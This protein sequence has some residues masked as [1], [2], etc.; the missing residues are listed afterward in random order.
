MVTAETGYFINENDEPVQ[1]AR[2]YDTFE[3]RGRSGDFLEVTLP[4]GKSAR[5]HRGQVHS[6]SEHWG[7]DTDRFEMTGSIL[8]LLQQ[9]EDAETFDQAESFLN[10]ATQRSRDAFGRQSLLVAW[11]QAIHAVELAE[12]GDM[13]SARSL[14]RKA[15]KRLEDPEHKDQLLTAEIFN[16]DGLIDT[17]SGRYSAA[18]KKFLTA[19][20]I[21]ERSLG[22]NHYDIA[23]YLQ[24]PAFAADPDKELAD[25]I[26]D[27]RAA[28]TILQKV[29][30][31]TAIE[32]PRGL[33]AL[34]DLYLDGDQP[35]QAIG[36]LM[37]AMG[38]LRAYHPDGKVDM[39]ICQYHLGEAWQQR[40]QYLEA[41]RW[42]NGIDVRL[43]NNAAA[44][45]RAEMLSL[46]KQI[47]H[48]LGHI[49]FE[50]RNFN[51]ALD[52]YMNAAELIDDDDMETLDGWSYVYA[53]D[54]LAEMRQGQ[55][56]QRLYKGAW[57]MF[58]KTDGPQSELAL[59]AKQL[60]TEAGGVVAANRTTGNSDSSMN[61]SNL[62]ETIGDAPQGLSE[63]TDA[64]ILGDRNSELAAYSM[65]IRRG[66][67]MLETKSDAPIMS[68]SDVLA[69]VPAATKLWSLE[70]KDG[71]HKVVIPG[72]ARRAWISGRFVES[73]YEAKARSLS[74][75]VNQ[76]AG[77]SAAAGRLNSQLLELIPR[78]AETAK[79][80]GLEAAVA[81]QERVVSLMEEA[82]GADSYMT[83]SSRSHLAI[84]YL[85]SRQFVK[86]RQLIEAALPTMRQ[87]HGD[88]HPLIAR[89]LTR[90]AGLLGMIGD[91]PGRQRCLSEALQIAIRRFGPDDAR[92]IGL[93]LNLAATHT[94]AGQFPQA[95]DLYNKIQ[96][97]AEGE[98]G[99]PIA[100]VF[101]RSGL[102]GLRVKQGRFSEAIPILEQ[103][104]Q[105]CLKIGEQVK[106]TRGIIAG[107]LALA[108]FSVE[109]IDAAEEQLRQATELLKVSGQIPIPTELQLL[110]LQTRLDGY[111]GDWA[112]S[113]RVTENV[114]ERA[115]RLYGD[116]S[117]H[118]AGPW[119]GRGRA[120]AHLG[121]NEA[122]VA[123]FHTARQIVHDHIINTLADL[124]VSQQ[125]AYLRSNDN[126]I[127]HV[128]LS[129]GLAAPQKE[130][131]AEATAT[132]MLNTK[133]IANELAARDTQVRRLCTADSH[134]ASHE[135]WLDG[136]R[137]L[138]TLPPLTDE[139]AR[140][141]HIQQTERRLKR[142][143][144]EA[145]AQLPDD[146]RNLL[147]KRR[148]PWVTCDAVRSKLRSGEVFIDFA[149]MKKSV[150]AGDSEAQTEKEMV[151]AA[152]IV[153]ANSDKPVQI[154]ELG[155]AQEIDDEIIEPYLN[156]IRSSVNK[157]RELGEDGALA[158]L[159]DQNRALTQRIW[160]PLLEKL[161]AD[162]SR[163]TLC[164]DSALWQIPWAAIEDTD[165]KL[166]LEN[167]TIRFV[168]SGRDLLN[169]AT[170]I[171]GLRP[172]MV[173]A[174]PDF[175]ATPDAIQNSLERL[176]LRSFSLRLENVDATLLKQI[177]PDQVARLTGTAAEAEAVQP[178]LTNHSGMDTEVF[179]RAAA[180]EAVL[181]LTRRPHTLFIGTHGFFLPEEDLPESDLLLGGGPSAGLPA[182]SNEKLNPLRRCGLL[183][184]GCS[185]S[186][187]TFGQD[188]LDGIVTGAEIVGLD[189]HG[190]KLVVLSACETGVGDLTSGQGVSGLRQAIQ[191][192][193]AESVV[194]T[195]WEIPDRETMP[196]MTAFFR[197]LASGKSRAES[198]RLA[199]LER[200]RARRARYGAAHPLFWA[201]FTVTGRD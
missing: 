133:N 58:E 137:R 112:E 142:S 97:Q 1:T 157:L 81:L 161:P 2:M 178:L 87:V 124:P 93:Q 159:A 42:Y 131:I 24:N 129:I 177:L 33:T 20:T 40:E 43:P 78:V 95:E 62:P 70:Q 100:A 186:P 60:F 50:R 29:L 23:V 158:E 66:E 28:N 65:V 111:R 130:Q 25:A 77:D 85:I 176:P 12:S 54:A 76:R 67:G 34:A 141:E 135:Q 69:Q 89:E 56:A 128:A 147:D 10:L 31:T 59:D 98:A 11:V 86:S 175:G 92:V 191:L 123:S 120:L 188:Q 9:A 184:A 63:K 103:A 151:Y 51:A 88:D 116:R 127:L 170:Q 121:Q 83:V 80:E 193:G 26:T 61:K 166:L 199:Q 108:L 122:A 71:W 163:L 109:E 91:E 139:E 149:R 46:R 5:I 19:V 53:A 68:G 118:L 165:R 102:G 146:A 117:V 187:T 148:T 35:V 168:S 183:L 45:D 180:S 8:K 181:R 16:A 21:A 17:E 200:I 173:L 162:T 57:L 90:L 164:P 55:R 126:P 94:N 150:L 115:A 101:A 152:W 37:S 47:Q 49:D 174:D 134:L 18:R 145:F 171:A 104:D 167:Y 195:L 110:A 6:L 119:T 182:E 64:E 154:V 185:G 3:V 156:E 144:V 4:S 192:A 172:P 27:L 153:S 73:E 113:L 106:N 201:A 105:E 39:A 138:A 44:E 107:T 114:R 96:A 32:Q 179:V 48:A 143:T 194:S 136:R 36:T 41:E 125:I 72:A 140:D 84:Y 99:D 169:E 52:H 190:T 15:G 82:L 198:L 22:R 160:L 38:L 13:K 30:P 189:L 79:T 155:S 74:A 132:W 197:N 196:L 75:L 14:I 7:V